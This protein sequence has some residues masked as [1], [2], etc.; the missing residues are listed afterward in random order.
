MG[1]LPPL[2][3]PML[4]TLAH[5]LPVPDDQ[6]GFEYKW[7]GVRAITYV[8]GKRVRAVSR[9]DL[10]ITASYPELAELAEL[11]TRPV[12]LDGEIVAI[13][14]GR[15]D[16]GFLQSRVHVLRP[17]DALLRE[18]PVEYYVFDVLHIDDP[19]LLG[20]PYVERRAVLD[21][22]ALTGEH[23]QTPP[24]FRGGGEQVLAASVELGLEGV[25]AKRLESRYVPG[26][27]SRDWL[28]VKHVRHQEVLVCGWRPGKGRRAGMIGCLLVGV[29]GDRGLEYTGNVGT[30]FTQAM[31]HD[32]A[33]RLEPLERQSSP[34]DTE[35]PR[36]Q[37]QDAHW[38]RPELV[39]EVAYSERTADGM[40]RHPSWR[41]LRTDKQPQDVRR[42]D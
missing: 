28:K 22:L 33:A 1:D 2:I 9:N 18:V 25:V 15:P 30:G 24:W 13:R 6:W 38:V 16:F 26:G 5:E 23:V 12:V 35:V 31:L 32:L 21:D 4:A 37:A 39:G 17:T 11:L 14:G 8:I 29:P 10:D 41:G 20:H 7:D 19:S 40:L 36:S 42:E 34:F 27:R 3:R